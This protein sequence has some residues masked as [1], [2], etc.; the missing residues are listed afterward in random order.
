MDTKYYRLKD[1]EVLNFK[2]RRYARML[3]AKAIKQGT[4]KRATCCDLC[5][6]QKSEIQAHHVDYGRPLDVLWLCT[7]CHGLAHR[8]RHK[9]NPNNNPQTPMPYAI[10][11]NELVPVTIMLPVSNFIHLQQVARH[12]ATPISKIIK[13]EILELYPI[14]NNQLELNLGG[15]TNDIAQNAGERRVQSLATNERKLLQ[16]KRARVSK[17]RS[18][19][20]SSMQRMENELFPVLQR[21]GTNAKNVQRPRAS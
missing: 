1:R 10:D 3:V 4:I 14:K 13:K 15:E 21:H 11:A 6:E 12:L 7:T 8:K 19:G 20:N 2:R 16:Q 9:L 17:V 5:K 18:K